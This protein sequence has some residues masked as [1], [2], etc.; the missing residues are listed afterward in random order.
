MIEGDSSNGDPS[1]E[2]T[3]IIT[4]PERFMHDG[5]LLALQF[6]KALGSLSN[7]LAANVGAQL[8]HADYVITSDPAV[9]R[10]RGIMPSHLDCMDCQQGVTRALE[11]LRDAPDQLLIVG[12]L[13]WV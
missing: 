1:G 13:Y 11:A 4:F 3:T 10:E 2:D 9:V 6:V 8:H 12:Q 5:A 7:L